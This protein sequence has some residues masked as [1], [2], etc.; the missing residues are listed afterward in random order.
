MNYVI[1]ESNY[2][3]SK[4]NYVKSKLNY[5]NLFDYR[6]WSVWKFL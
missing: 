6:C 1:F 4:L 5:V 3:K 2:V